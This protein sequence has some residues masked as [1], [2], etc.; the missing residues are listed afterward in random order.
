M[1]KVIEIYK[2]DNHILND[3][4]DRIIVEVY[5]RRKKDGIKTIALTGCGSGNGTTTSA[6]NIS[7]ALAI[8]GW[9]TI[10]IDCDIRK[11]SLYKRL[12]NEVVTGLSDYIT[13]K[14]T[15]QIKDVV[16]RTNTEKLYYLP[17]GHLNDN[18]IRLLCSARMEELVEKLRN[19]YDYIIFDLPSITI[20]ADADILFPIVDGIILVAA[21]N[22]TTKKQL[23]IAREKVKKFSDKYHGLIVNKVDMNQYRKYNKDFDY[24]NE[25]NLKKKYKNLVSKHYSTGEKYDKEN[26]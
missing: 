16:Y 12:N 22:I 11:G 1:D 14:D 17:C 15:Y 7:L 20:M 9:K 2:N 25:K 18:P 21:L 5:S 26:D 23:Y 3:A 24:F 4:I 10:L 19:E 6:I 13:Y 8:A